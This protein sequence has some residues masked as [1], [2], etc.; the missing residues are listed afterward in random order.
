MGPTL[1][2]WFFRA[3]SM[4]E[5]PEGQ[6]DALFSEQ[7]S[8]FRRDRY[9]HPKIDSDSYR[10]AVTGMKQERVFSLPD[11]VSLGRDDEIC[12]MECAGNGN[13]WMGSAG[14]VGQAKW[15]GVRVER[16]LEACGGVGQA[17]HIVARSNDSLWSRKK[18][19]HYGLSVEE[20]VSAGALLATHF[21]DEPLTRERGYPVRLIVPGI[22][23]MSHVKWVTRLDGL[24]QP[25]QG[26]YN[27]RVYTN[28]R[29]VA[30]KWER[31]E[32]RWIGLKAV[33]TRC[34]RTAGGYELRGQAWGGG[35]A[36][37]RVEVTLDGGATWQAT[38]LSNVAALYSDTPSSHSWVPFRYAWDAPAPGVYTVGARAYGADG[39]VQPLEQPKDLVGHFDQTRV[40]WR[41]VRVPDPKDSS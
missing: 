34:V 5:V 23:S 29:R 26:I 8:F 31:E 12:V 6:R 9:V 32:A 4:V 14:L 28:K 20:L 2:R 40:S 39:S 13:H 10:L 3:I 18:G 21:N 7:D 16:V 38:A 11:L 19:Y 17:T 30:G 41:R 15:T 25:H 37:S 36:V 33:L 24:T 22:Y 27:R 35:T 1:F